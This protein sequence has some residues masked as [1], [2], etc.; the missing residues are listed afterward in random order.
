MLKLIG[1]KEFDVCW[2]Q[3]AQLKCRACVTPL[4]EHLDTVVLQLELDPAWQCLS[5]VIIS[6]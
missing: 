6:S 1:K 5:G 4:R 2:D 3:G